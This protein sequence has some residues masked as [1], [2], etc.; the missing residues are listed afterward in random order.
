VMNKQK[1]TDKKMEDLLKISMG[2]SPREILAR[3]RSIDHQ[4]E[5]V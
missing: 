1:I 2:H 4:M 5:E 3:L